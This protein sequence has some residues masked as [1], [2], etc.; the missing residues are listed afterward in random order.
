MALRR[1]SAKSL[2]GARRVSRPAALSA[3]FG[4]KVAVSGAVGQETHRATVK[5]ALSCT[6]SW[7]TI[8]TTG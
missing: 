2:I 6:V 8:I 5:V 1:D 3:G 7:K 4:A